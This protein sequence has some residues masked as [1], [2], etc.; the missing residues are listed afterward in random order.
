MERL[1]TYSWPHSS[2]DSGLLLC[3]ACVGRV[4]YTRSVDSV[5][6]NYDTANAQAVSNDDHAASL[7]T[8]FL[9]V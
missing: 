9:E 4:D 3:T 2:M 5:R 1:G 6:C 7:T 8:P